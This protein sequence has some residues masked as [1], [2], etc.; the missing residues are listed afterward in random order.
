MKKLL[1]LILLIPLYTAAQRLPYE[2]ML[3][4]RITEADKTT[5]AEI[6]PVDDE[7]NIATDRLY[8][9]YSAN[10]IHQTQGGYSGKLLNGLFEEYYFNKNLKTQGS[11]KKGLKSGIWKSWNDNGS[12]NEEM[13]WKNGLKNGHFYQYDSAGHLK[14]TGKYKNDLL[15]GKVTQI[16]EKGTE[17]I[18]WYKKGV[19]VKSRTKPFWKK[20]KIPHWYKRKA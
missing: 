15:N 17:E 20:L 12:L 8:Y 11:F 16:N 5:V 7:P 14:E 9:W 3:K 10:R 4:V 6:R 19:V 1:F 18:T 13:T 2:A